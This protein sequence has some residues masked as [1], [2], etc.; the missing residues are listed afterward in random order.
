[1]SNTQACLKRQMQQAR[2]YTEALLA[3]FKTPEQWLH[4]V[5]PQA[6]HALWFAGHMA[7]ADNYFVSCL[8]PDKAKKFPSYD[9]QFGMGSQPTA[10]AAKYPP[11][12]EVLA[13]MR[14]R[15]TT[16]MELLDSLKEDDLDKA[17]A[18]GASDFLPTVGKVFE[19]AVWH[20]GLHSGQISVTRRALGHKPVFGGA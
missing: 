18:S 19:V 15:R 11:I 12:E 2:Q 20:E 9:T 6:N 8:A 7:T 4:Q 1:M 10:E 13:A 17:P 5:H 14:E 16:L 3:D